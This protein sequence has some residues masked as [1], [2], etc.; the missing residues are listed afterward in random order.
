[1]S[2]PLF[3]HRLQ[4]GFTAAFHY[5]FPQ[6]TMGLAVFIVLFLVLAR[7][8]GQERYRDAARFWIRIFGVNFA[9]GVVTGIPLEFQFGTNWASFSAR[10]GGVI[11]QTLAMEGMFA[12]FLESSFLGILV[13]GERKL[14][15]RIHE[16][17]AWALLAG[18]WLSGY[19]IIATNAFMQHPVGHRITADG[20]FELVSFFSFLLNPWA[21]VEYA[22]TMVASVVTASF[23]VAA[24]G[25]FYTLRRAHAEHAPIFLRTGVVLGLLASVAVAFPTGDLQGKMV[26]RHQ[27]TTLAA[28]EGRWNSGTWAE[29]NFIGQ[30][31]VANQ[32]LDNPIR[33]PG[34]LSFIAYGS[35]DSHVKGLSEFPHEDWPPNI[36]LLY[37]GFHIMVG[38]GTIFI[39]IM[40]LAA[41]FTWRKRLAEKRWL[42]WILMLA[43]PFPYI[44]TT[45]GWITTEL[46]RQPWLVYGLLRTR[47]GASPLVHGGQ[48]VFTSLGFAG[49][50]VVLGFLFVYLVMREVAHG[51]TPLPPSP[52]P[53][54]S[55]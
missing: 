8:T 43:F 35:F 15:R 37:Y 42:L 27:P 38:L 30:P 53:A 49:I 23:V 40:L 48:T 25:A 51:P 52:A 24:V 10:T 20:T 7:R 19:F 39:A 36:E 12:F 5:L 47:D 33:M 44:A 9:I 28:M 31:D 21:L 17:A 29:L 14:G 13:F 18:T 22:H 45:A 16:A 55:P 34:L 3:W 26:A 50:Y 54:A 32:R 2:D 4:F 11:G 41:Y 6:L 46:G 1:M